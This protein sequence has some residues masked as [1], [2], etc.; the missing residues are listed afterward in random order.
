[1]LKKLIMS[2]LEK[3]MQTGSLQ[4]NPFHLMRNNKSH[5]TQ[6]HIR[7]I[8]ITDY[9][10]IQLLGSLTSS[11]VYKQPFVRTTLHTNM[12]SILPLLFYINHHS[13]LPHPTISTSK[14]YFPLSS[15]QLKLIPI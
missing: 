8:I 2:T 10:Y 11:L 6:A 12:M 4:S 14:P 15:H 5:H 3:Q 1:M 7:Y 13:S 9:M